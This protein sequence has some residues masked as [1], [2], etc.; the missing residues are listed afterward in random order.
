MLLNSLLL[1]KASILVYLG[2]EMIGWR[3]PTLWRTI[4]FTP[5]YWVKCWFHPKTPLQKHLPKC[6]T[7]KLGTVGKPC[8]H[9]KLTFILS[10]MRIWCI[11][12]ST[13]YWALD[14][15]AL[16]LVRNMNW[17]IL[18][19][20]HTSEP[21]LSAAFTCG[22]VQAL[23]TSEAD[24]HEFRCISDAISTSHYSD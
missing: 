14:Y 11:D 22:L 1:G 18:H 9:V 21:A 6:V 20:W 24:D 7:T 12:M 4:C 19:F 17:V 15:Q 8:W 3:L 2:P 10:I 16:W 5:S 23:C 13:A